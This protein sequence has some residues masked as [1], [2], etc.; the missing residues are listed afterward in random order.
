M[1]KQLSSIPTNLIMGFLGVG[2]TTAILDLLQQKP[3]HENWAVLVN[4]FGHVGIDGA[5]FSSQGAT[6]REIPGGCLCCAVG[7]PFQVAVNRLLA[8]VKPD[9]LLIEPTGLGH[10]KRVLDML[11]K[12]FFRSVLDVQACICLLDPRK[13]K[14]SRYTNHENFVDQIYL[15]D[16][17]VA[18]KTDLAEPADMRLFQQWVEHSVPAKTVYAK[19]VQGRLDIAWLSL[20]RNPDRSARFAGAHQYR[21]ATTPEDSVA[22]NNALITSAADGYQSCGWVFSKDN[23]FDHNHLNSYLTSISLDRI[24]AVVLTNKGWYIVNSAAAEITISPCKPS[25]NSRIEMIAQH[26]SWNAIDILLKQ[27]LLNPEAAKNNTSQPLD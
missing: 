7:L 15:A 2:K 17:L 26:A 5:I 22:R 6:V 10:P 14:D 20:T 24:K 1:K 11:T 4:E 9:R 16:I 3:D 12:D 23:P 19:T 21:K 18:N 25:T 13:L 27:C 8:E